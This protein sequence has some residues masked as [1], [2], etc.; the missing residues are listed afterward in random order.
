M[1]GDDIGSDVRGAQAVGSTGVL[2]KTGKFRPADLEGNQVKPNH[3]IDSI[4]QL[5]D[6]LLQ[7]VDHN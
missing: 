6:L 2:V 1:V 5:P 3:V 4:G 7:L